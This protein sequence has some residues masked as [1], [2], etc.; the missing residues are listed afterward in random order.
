MRNIVLNT[1]TRYFSDTEASTR[2]SSQQPASSSTPPQSPGGTL[3]FSVSALPPP[4]DVPPRSASIPSN[5]KASQSTRSHL[6]ERATSDRRRKALE[7][8]LN[9]SRSTSG[10]SSTPEGTNTD[11]TPLAKPEYPPTSLQVTFVPSSTSSAVSI[12]PEVATR[13]GTRD[14]LDVEE[15]LT[16]V[17][18]LH[19]A[20]TLAVVAKELGISEEADE[21]GTGP[22]IVYPP[23]SR[24]TEQRSPDRGSSNREATGEGAVDDGGEEDEEAGRV[25]H[26][27][28]PLVGQYALTVH[29]EAKSG[30]VEL[31]SAST[32]AMDATEESGLATGIAGM[33]SGDG[34]GGGSREARLRSATDRLNSSRFTSGENNPDAWIKS[35]PEVIAKIRATVSLPVRRPFTQI[36]DI[37]MCTDRIG[38]DLDPLQ[39]LVSADSTPAPASASR[40]LEI[41]PPPLP[42]ARSPNFPLRAPECALQG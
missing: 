35:L 20:E 23:T 17:V 16:R 26:L 27:V 24:T 3:I 9:R 25:P 2:N 33:A 8:L 30:R 21:R 34:E 38:R 40:A 39:S 11:D 7:S 19:A 28:V 5:P 4:P 13:R 15:I 41:R 6:N 10:P 36:T 29:V 22:R 1:L 18:N 31:R 12:S 14:N 32:T 42:R 37:V